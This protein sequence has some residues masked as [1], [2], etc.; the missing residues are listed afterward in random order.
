MATAAA[1]LAHSHAAH[2]PIHPAHMHSIRVE[3]DDSIGRSYSA[4][5]KGAGNIKRGLGA[6]RR[7][8]RTRS[9]NPAGPL[10]LESATLPH[11][12]RATRADVLAYFRNTW[13]MTDA[14]FAGLRDDS[15]FYMVPDKLRRP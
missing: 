14:L 8:L 12:E 7:S 3:A 15:V 6:L 5:D 1:Q 9:F 2:P 10:T 11:L 13:E 4:V